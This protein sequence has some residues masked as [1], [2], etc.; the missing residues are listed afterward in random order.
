MSSFLKAAVEAAKIGGKIQMR[1]FG[2]AIDIEYKTHGAINLVTEVDRLCE[3]AILAHLKKRFPRHA[4]WGE[5]TGRGN[6]KAEF[7]WI[8]DPLDGTTNYT[9]GYPFFNTSVALVQDDR[10][11]AG[12]VF[13]PVKEELFT[14]EK[15][16]GAFLNGK[17]LKVSSVSKLEQA[18]LATGFAYGVKETTYN[19]DNFKRFI[20]ASQGVRRDGSAA[21]NLC[22]TAAGRF[23]GFWERG[24]QAWDMAAGILTALEA[25]ALVTD[26]TGGPWNL[27]GQNA[28]VSNGLIHKDMLR[29]LVTGPDEKQWR[30]R[31]AETNKTKKTE[32]V[33]QSTVSDLPLFNIRKKA[34]RSKKR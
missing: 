8:V 23:D 11:I 7:T 33:Q 17:R 28:L 16:R 9:H 5:E 12:A 24:I 22:Y 2:K 1:Y 15:E 19:L 34:H 3:K 26:V 4:L 25:G 20:L 31:Q 29:I 6:K 10:P 21:L 13:D 14:A 18:L 27:Y 32:D 30:A